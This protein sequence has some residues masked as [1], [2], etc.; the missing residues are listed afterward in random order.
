MCIPSHLKTQKFSARRFAAGGHFFLP[1]VPLAA[2]I[3]DA[4]SQ[5]T[6]PTPCF[7]TGPRAFHLAN[8]TVPLCKWGTGASP[9]DE[10]DG[11]GTPQVW[12]C[13]GAQGEVFQ[14]EQAVGQV[15]RA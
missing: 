10:G 7:G 1:T 3:S 13:E 5:T 14:V 2:L 15:H 4:R 12:G 8:G 9:E 6:P 11:D